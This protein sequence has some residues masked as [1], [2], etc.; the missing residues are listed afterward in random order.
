MH[1]VIWI[2]VEADGESEAIERAESHFHDHLHYEQPNGY[3]DYCQPMVSGHTVAGAD[4]WTSYADGPAAFPADSEQGLEE[5]E[6]AWKITRKEFA[7]AL[8]QVLC[9]FVD[10][11]PETLQTL[12]AERPSVRAANEG[13][14][15]DYG[16]RESLLSEDVLLEYQLDDDRIDPRGIIDGDV[17]DA[18]I[19]EKF[20]SWRWSAER[21]GEDATGECALYDATYYDDGSGS[22]VD[23]VEKYEDTVA[24]L[25]GKW[26]VPLDVHS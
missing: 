15:Y 7:D 21:L 6:L 24:D 5:L 9:A 22:H 19:G 23:S 17:V 26:I 12:L 3:Y 16:Y 14:R 18:L 10:H 13:G 11:I 20:N 2:V 4:R 25:E 8:A 1:R